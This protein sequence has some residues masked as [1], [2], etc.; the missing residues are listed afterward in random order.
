MTE[1][2]VAAG[3]RDSLIYLSFS[4]QEGFSLSAME[5]MA[6]GC[7]VVGYHGIAASEYFKEEFCY[8]INSDDIINY[9]KT[10]EA[11]I[12]EYS[13]NSTRILAKGR[14]ASEFILKTYSLEREANDVVNFWRGILK[15]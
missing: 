9:A 14:K 15:S 7:V 2:E 11:V 5:A 12:K 6:C 8:P 1:A 4:N 3:M 13:E 10:V